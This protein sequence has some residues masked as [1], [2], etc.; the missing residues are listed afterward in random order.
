MY[1]VCYY[2]LDTCE[3]CPHAC[4]CIISLNDDKPGYF[5]DY[6]DTKDFY[7]R[8]DYLAKKRKEQEKP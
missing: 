6:E 3:E 2:G 7:A 8:L 1:D 4:E 5:G